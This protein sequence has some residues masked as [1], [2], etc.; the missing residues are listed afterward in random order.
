MLWIENVKDNGAVGKVNDGYATELFAVMAHEPQDSY[1]DSYGETASEVSRLV[2][3]YSDPDDAARCVQEISDPE[4]GVSGEVLTVPAVLDVPKELRVDTPAGPITAKAS[5]DPEYPGI[6]VTYD[7]GDG[8]PGALLEYTPSEVDGN[9][10]VH[11]CVMLRVYGPEDPD[12]DPVQAYRMSCDIPMDRSDV[13]S[14]IVRR[15]NDPDGNGRRIA[16]NIVSYAAAQG[17][18]EEDTAYL[19]DA[20]LQ[21]A[22]LA[23]SEIRLMAKAICCDG[24]ELPSS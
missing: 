13:S 9:M 5:G 23:E 1:V 6:W 8:E 20:L 12:G 14:M 15:L 16:D 19:L 24:A 10:N 18:D 4:S 22:G 11:K 21:G 17:M 3:I 7:G 2:G